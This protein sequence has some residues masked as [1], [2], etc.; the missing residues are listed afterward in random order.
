LIEDQRVNKD[1]YYYVRLCVDGVWRYV[2]VDDWLPFR[3]KQAMHAGPS[4]DA[5]VKY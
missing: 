4:Q 3:E 2:L 5:R 1:G